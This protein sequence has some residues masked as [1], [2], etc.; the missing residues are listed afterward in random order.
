MRSLARCCQ[1]DLAE[2]HPGGGLLVRR[3]VPPLNRRQVQRL[4]E[5]L[6]TAHDEWQQA[7]LATPPVE[8]LRQRCRRLA[9]SLFELGEDVEATERQLHRWRFHPRVAREATAWAWRRHTEA[10]EAAEAWTPDDAA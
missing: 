10:K 6:R 2:F 7:Q 3:K 8:Q 1:F 5:P 4:S 9:L